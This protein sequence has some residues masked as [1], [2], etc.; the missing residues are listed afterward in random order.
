MFFDK[1]ATLIF[2]VTVRNSSVLIIS[3]DLFF[4]LFGRMLCV[5]SRKYHCVLGDYKCV[6]IL[7]CSEWLIQY[8]ATSVLG[9]YYHVVLW[10]FRVLARMLLLY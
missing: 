4:Y 3:A 5:L 1:C 2:T 8:H 7:R 9:V 10:L 6:T